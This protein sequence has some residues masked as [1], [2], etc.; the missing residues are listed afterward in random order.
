MNHMQ[1]NAIENS[2]S[3]L[4]LFRGSLQWLKMDVGNRKK[5]TF[6]QEIFKSS[7]ISMK[8]LCLSFSLGFFSWTRLTSALFFFHS[9]SHWHEN[10]LPNFY[11]FLCSIRS[12]IMFGPV[13]HLKFRFI[14]NRCCSASRKEMNQ[15]HRLIHKNGNNKNFIAPEKKK[16]VQIVI[17]SE[18]KQQN[19]PTSSKHR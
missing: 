16:L 18:I 4:F 5:R 6:V 7:A 1:R 14:W 13:C 8:R 17:I 3:F 9:L 19:S 12:M 2:L 10:P 11:V 15:K